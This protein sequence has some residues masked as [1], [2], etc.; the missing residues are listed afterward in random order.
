MR[1]HWYGLQIFALL[2]AVFIVGMT[3]AKAQTRVRPQSSRTKTQKPAGEVASSNSAEIAATKA[4]IE[5][6]KVLLNQMR[7]NLGFVQTS[8]TPLKHQFELEADMWGVLI[9]SMERHVEALEKQSGGGSPEP[10][11]SRR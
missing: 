11:V 3:E 2:V 10:G 5:K 1:G 9:Q 7:V 4:D 8:Q 6:M